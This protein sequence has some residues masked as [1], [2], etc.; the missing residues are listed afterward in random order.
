MTINTDHI[1]EEIKTAK[2]EL[3]GGTVDFKKAFD[4]MDAKIECEIREIKGLVSRAR[5]LFRKFPSTIC[6]LLT[7]ILLT[8]FAKGDV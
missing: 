8:W 6:H 7:M 2:S 4:L 3:S 5:A 1:D